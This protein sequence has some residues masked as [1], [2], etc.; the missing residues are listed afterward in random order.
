MSRIQLITDPKQA[1]EVGRMLKE[2]AGEKHPVLGELS[3]TVFRG[4][5]LLVLYNVATQRPVSINVSYY[6]K[7]KKNIFEPYLNWYIAY[8]LPDFRRRGLAY[9]LYRQTEKTALER[10]CRRVRSLAGS[11]AGAGLHLAL[12]HLFWGR[13]D[14]GELYVDAPLPGMEHLYEGKRKPDMVPLDKPMLKQEV[15][16]IMKEGLRYDTDQLRTRR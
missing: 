5:E 4:A 12:G 7:R 3:L 14:T 8:T 11:A 1:T 13:K 6:G 15:T 9:N 10:G 16:R 2:D